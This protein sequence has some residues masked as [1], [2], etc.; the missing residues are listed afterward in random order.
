MSERGSYTYEEIKGQTAA[1]EDAGSAFLAQQAA[2][3]NAWQEAGA[4]RVLF[5]G[6]GSTYYLSQTAASLF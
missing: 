5:T 6:C 2:L 1:W 4:R 3:L